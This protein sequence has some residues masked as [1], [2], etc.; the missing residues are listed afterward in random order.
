MGHQVSQ[1]KKVKLPAARVWDVLKDYSGI[2]KFA[3]TVKAS[4]IVGDKESGVGAKRKVTLQHDG[5]TMIEEIIE[6]HEGQGYKMEVSELSS[7]LKTMQ[8]EFKVNEVDANTSEICMTVEFEVKGG[9]FGW[10]MGNMMM[11]PMMKGVLAK[12]LDGLAYHSATGKTVDAKLP[13][14]E[15]LASAIGSES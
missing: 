8:A 3:P 12:N 7:P 14:K 13:S 11:K 2:E 15:E 5:S 10:I 4:A 6:F 1:I 9:P